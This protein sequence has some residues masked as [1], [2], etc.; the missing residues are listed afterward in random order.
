[1]LSSI[2][3]PVATVGSLMLSIVSLVLVLTAP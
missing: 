1:M 3:A 2:I